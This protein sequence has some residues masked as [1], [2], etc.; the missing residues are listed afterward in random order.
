MLNSTTPACSN[1][2]QNEGIVGSISALG[3][4]LLGFMTS[5][6]VSNREAIGKW[7][8][9]KI[10][11]KTPTPSQNEPEETPRDLNEVV[12]DDEDRQSTPITI[13]VRSRANSID[14]SMKPSISISAIPDKDGS[15][16]IEISDDSPPKRGRSQKI[17]DKKEDKKNV[18]FRRKSAPPL[19]RRKAEDLSDKT[20]TSHRKK[21]DSEKQKYRNKAVGHTQK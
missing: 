12:V 2:N 9:S 7:I 4:G 3:A 10:S 19:S 6:L 13:K 21:L 17:E 8:L 5:F 16:Q 18:K 1:N 11:K 15:Y 14:G 20:V